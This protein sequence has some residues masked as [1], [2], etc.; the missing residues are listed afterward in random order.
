MP[1]RSA[2]SPRTVALWLA[3][4]FST[5]GNWAMWREVGNLIAQGRFGGGHPILLAAALGVVVF[6]LNAVLTLLFA[7]PRGMK[8]VWIALAVVAGVAQHYM[9]AYGTVMDPGMLAN[10]FQTDP[11]EVRDLLG[12]P[13]LGQVLLVAGPPAL[14]LARLPLQRFGAWGQLWRTLATLAAV[15]AAAAAV[16]L[17][18]YR[19]L[20]PMLRNNDQLRFMTNP[21]SSVYSAL[22]AATKPLRKRGPRKLVAIGAGAKLGPSYASAAA[23]SR[24]PLFVLVVGETARADHFGL[25]GYPRDTTPE[26]AARDVDSFRDVRSCGTNTLA[27]VPCMFSPLGKQGYESRKVD[28]ENLLDVL[29]AAGLG[30]VWIDNQAGCKTVCDRVLSYTTDDAL[31]ARDPAAKAL[32]DGGECLDSV[33]LLNLDRRIAALP[34]ERR[35][36]GIVVVMHQ[37]GSHGPA[38]YRR[39][40]P[41]NKRFQPECATNEL[42]KCEHGALINVYDNSIAETDRFLGRTID[43]LKARQDRFATGMLYLSDHGESLGEYGL[44]LHGLPY[45]LAPEVQKHVPMVLWL[46]DGFARRQGLDRGCIRAKRDE[47][48]THDNLFHTVLGTLDVGTP[49]YRPALDAFAACRGAPGL[50]SGRAGA[51]QR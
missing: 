42:S 32:C 18:H 24:P 41:E 29:Q 47:A 50:A 15:L 16:A 9:L 5:V 33:M 17:A 25:N 43:W 6:A 11:R 39:S 46:G 21:A 27:S 34:E 22:N 14:W 37:M 28:Y 45:A 30:V 10:V 1:Q 7:W 3:L 2:R 35:R 20:A 31:G 12:L 38:Y 44:F 26:L 13:L 23:A 36:N 51:A 40:A 4:W 49:T 8:P 19:E 48:L